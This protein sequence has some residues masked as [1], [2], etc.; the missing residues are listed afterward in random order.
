MVRNV[1]S[2]FLALPHALGQQVFDLAVDGAEIVLRPSGNG[3]IKLDGKPE[4][5]LFFLMIRH[6]Q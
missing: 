6:N 3:V 1:F 4:R 5:D 2:V